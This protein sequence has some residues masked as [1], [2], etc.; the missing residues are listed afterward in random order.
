[1]PGARK[2]PEWFIERRPCPG[3]KHRDLVALVTYV[4]QHMATSFVLS[5]KDEANK[6][7]LDLPTIGKDKLDELL[8]LRTFD[9]TRG[10]VDGGG[11]DENRE[12]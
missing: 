12:R 5:Q 4:M 11:P 8:P 7:G 10:I 1:M 2:T 3:A 9:R 6:W